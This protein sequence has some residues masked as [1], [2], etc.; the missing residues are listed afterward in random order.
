MNR[1]QGRPALEHAL[2]SVVLPVYN[3]GAV[4]EI[5][6]RRVRRALDAAGATAEIVFVNDGSRDAS[7]RVLDRLAARYPGV[8]VLHFSRNFGHQAAIQAGLAAARGDAIVLMDSDLQDEPEAIG[9]FLALWQEGYDVVYA[10][11]AERQ[12]QWWKRLLFAGFHRLLSSVANVPIPVDAGN[13]SLIDA[14][15]AAEIV[16]LGECD[17]YLPGLRSWVGYRQIGLPVRRNPRYDDQPRVSLRG[18]WRLAKT[19]IFS[20]STAPL[21]VFYGIGYASLGVFAALSVGSL[22][23]KFFTDWTTPGWTSGVL[24]ASFFGAVNALGV[25]MLGEYVVRIYDQ[26]RGRPHYIIARREESAARATAGR[27][28]PAR[29]D[30]AASDSHGCDAGQRCEEGPDLALEGCE[31]GVEA[32]LARDVLALAA[33]TPE[34]E[35]TGHGDRRRE[36]G[37]AGAA[38]DS[39]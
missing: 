31:L 12:E 21:S 26:V 7:P 22:F 1:P 37:A 38:T 19:A 18:L 2:V 39:Q 27:S 28:L 8:R 30:E 13:F 5:L 17:R 25:S 15:L 4:L 32:E 9:S 6:H 29:G 11:R 20:F 10:V 33:L 34:G 14:R 3:E 16:A 24:V 36:A 35:S 23:C